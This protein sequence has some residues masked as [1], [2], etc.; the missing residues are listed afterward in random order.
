MPGPIDDLIKDFPVTKSTS[1]KPQ[2]VA[3]DDLIASFPVTPKAGAGRETPVPRGTNVSRATPL[4]SSVNGTNADEDADNLSYATDYMHNM[5]GVENKVEPARKVTIQGITSD[6][7]DAKVEERTYGGADVLQGTTAKKFVKSVQVPA[8]YTED[9]AKRAIASEVNA[10]KAYVAQDAQRLLAILPVQA[11]DLLKKVGM[12]ANSLLQ[13]LSSSTDGQNELSTYYKIRTDVA[14]NEYEQKK[15]AILNSN[16]QVVQDQQQA[17]IGVPFDPFEKRQAVIDQQLSELK[18]GHDRELDKIHNSVFNMAAAKVVNKEF[19]DYGILDKEGAEQA[20]D[21]VSKMLRPEEV[22]RKVLAI[23]GDTA[24]PDNVLKKVM[25]EKVGYQAMKYAMAD[26]YSKG[27]L[28]LA[29]VLNEQT[30]DADRKILDANP[31]YKKTVFANA[32]SKE[33]DKRANRLTNFFLG[34]D[35]DKKFIDGIGQEMGIK[36]EDYKDVNPDDIYQSPNFITKAIGGFLKPVAEFDQFLFDVSGDK[37]SSFEHVFNNSSFG[38]ALGYNKTAENSVDLRHGGTK[39]DTNPES[40]TYGTE[41]PVSGQGKYNLGWNTLGSEIVNGVSTIA[42]MALGSGEISEALMANKLI[43][44]TNAA[45]R[46]GLGI[47]SYVTGYDRSY[48]R[49][50]QAIGSDPDKEPERIGLANVYSTVEALSLQLLPAKQVADK[51]MN[52]VAGQGLV[53]LVMKKGINKVTADMAKPYIIK[54]LQEGLLD[55]GKGVGM[56]VANVL[57]TTA[58]DMA[59]APKTT[60]HD[61]VD[62]VEESVIIGAIQM[63]IPT[64][65]GGIIN[66]KNVGPMHKRAMYEIGTNPEPFIADISKQLT[67]QK[68]T[69]DEARQRID[70]INSIADVYKNSVPSTSVMT[71][72]N[73]TQQQ[74]MDYA[75]SLV[76]EQQLR[77]Q[78]AKTKDQVQSNVLDGQVRDLQAEREDILQS[79]GAQPSPGENRIKISDIVGQKVMYEGKPATISVDE[80]NRVIVTDQKTGVEYDNI[81]NILNVGDES[82]RD[83]G[84]DPLTSVVSVSDAGNIA[85]RGKE[86]ISPVDNP[87]SAINYHNEPGKKGVPVSVTLEQAL[88]NGSTKKVTFRGD[89][90]ED[91][92]YQLHLQK[93]EK[94]NS[95]ER[96]EKFI[97]T[98][99]EARAAIQSEGLPKAA[100]G[101]AAENIEQ[102]SPVVNEGEVVPGEEFPLTS[103]KPNDGKIDEKAQN[104]PDQKNDG[105]NQGGLPE[106]Q[107]LVKVG[108]DDGGK[109]GDEQQKGVKPQKE[110][111]GAEPD[112]ANPFGFESEDPTFDLFNQPAAPE[113]PK[114]PVVEKAAPAS[115]PNGARVESFE[116]AKGSQYVYE[117]DGKT[118]RTTKSGEKNEAQDLI[119]FSKFG[120]ADQEQRFLQGV[121]RS[122]ETGTKVYVID[123]DGKVYDTNEQVKGKD[124]RL[125]LVETATGKILEIADTKQEPTVGYSTFDQRRFDE[126]GVAKRE[127]HIGNPVAKINY[128]PEAVPQAA[129]KGPTPEQQAKAA[130]D[131]FFAPAI[132]EREVAESAK[133]G[134]NVKTR[135]ANAVKVLGRK[136]TKVLNDGSKVDGHYVLTTSDA[137]TPS[138][139][140]KTFRTSEGFPLLEDGRNPNDRDYT[141]KENSDR[142]TIRAANFDGRA[143]EKVPTVDKNGIVIDGNDRTMS[144]QIAAK[145]GTDK[146]YIEAL[147][148]KAD[149]YGFTPEQIEA[150]VKDGKHPRVVF[151]TDKVM[152]YDTHTFSIFNPKT[153]GKVKTPIEEAI[154][155]GRTIDNNVLNGIGQVMNGFDSLAKFFTSKPGSKMVRDI[156]QRNGVFNADNVTGYYRDGKFTNAGKE[157]LQNIILGKVFNEEVLH[158][159]E[160]S[161]AVREKVVYS[162]SNLISIEALGEGYSLQTHLSDALRLKDRVD[163]ILSGIEDKDI[164]KHLRAKGQEDNRHAVK[165]YGLNLFLQQGDMFGQTKF[166][167][168]AVLIWHLLEDNTKKAF[169]DFTKEYL[170]NAKMYNQNSAVDIFGNMRPTREELIRNYNQKVKEYEAT[171]E[172]AVAG[173]PK[174][175]DFDVNAGAVPEVIDAGVRGSGEPK[176]ADVAEPAIQADLPARDAEVEGGEWEALFA[177]PTPEVLRKIAEQEQMEVANAKAAE[178]ENAQVPESKVII[179]PAKPANNGDKS[180]QQQFNEAKDTVLMKERK[181]EG[182]EKEHDTLIRDGKKMRTPDG[183]AA[184]KSVEAKLDRERAALKSAKNKL[185]LAE[186]NVGKVVAKDLAAEIRGRKLDENAYSGPSRDVHGGIVDRASLFDDEVVKKIGV[187][188][189]NAALEVAARAIELGQNVREA[190]Q[191]AVDHIN[192]RH[193]TS[194]NEK[195]FRDNLGEE[196]NIKTAADLRNKKLAEEPLSEKNK[197]AADSLVESV[198]ND[199][200]SLA[201]ALDHIKNLKMDDATKKKLS[202]YIRNRVTEEIHKASG[203]QMAAKHLKLSK[204][205]FDE[206]IRTLGEEFDSVM[207]NATSE[208]Q[209][210]NLRNKFAAAKSGLQSVQTAHAVKNGIITPNTQQAPPT[211]TRFQM[212]SFSRNAAGKLTGKGKFQKA[213]SDLATAVQDK[214]SPLER[215]QE[216]S[217]VPIDEHN[218]AVTAMR[219]KKSKAW[220]KISQMRDYLGN[221]EHKKGSLFDR[222]KKADINI[223][224]FGL[225]LYAKHAKE[226]NDYNAQLRQRIFDAKVYELNQK[227]AQAQGKPHLQKR[228]ADQLQEIL[229]QKDS[230]YA[231]MPDG[232]SGMT[233]LQAQDILDEVALDPKKAEYEAFEQEFRDNV[234]GK[235]L[236]TKHEAG[237]ISDEDYQH[238]KHYYKNYVPL[239]VKDE[240]ILAENGGIEDNKFF[241]NS[242]INGRELYRS[243]GADYRSMLD[244][245]NPLLQAAMD[246]EHSFVKGEENKANTVLSNFVRSN[247]NESIWE[248]KSA[249]YEYITDANGN[250]VKAFEKDE[251]RPN[252]AIPYYENGAKKYIILRDKNL[253]LMN[254]KVGNNAFLRM[255]QPVSHFIASVNTLS[256]P[257]FFLKNIFYDQQDAYMSLLGNENPE[258]V[259]KFRSYNPA[260]LAKEIITGKTTGDWAKWVQEWKDNGGAISFVDAITTEKQ[261]ELSSKVFDGYDKPFSVSRRRAVLEK[262]KEFATV[263][264]QTTRV[265]AYRAAVE[266]EAARI[267]KDEGIPVA[268]AMD[269]VN[270]DK[271]AVVS[272]NA[273]VDFEKKGVYG[274]YISSFKAFANA[275]IQGT[276]NLMYLAA[277][278]PKVRKFLG[279]MVLAGVAE[280]EVARMLGD[281]DPPSS[282]DCYLGVPDWRKERNFLIPMKPFGGQGFLSI[283]LGRNF[284]WFN[285]VGKKIDEFVHGEIDNAE[286][287]GHS[288]GSML[289]YYDP[290]GGT[291]PIEQKMAGNLAPVVQL[292]TNKSHFGQ[293]IE[294]ENKAG[295]FPSENFFPKT[296]EEFVEAAHFLHKISGGNAEEPG[297]IEISPDKLQ[298]TVQSIFGGLGNFAG[299]TYGM[300]ENAAAGQGTKANDV[301]IARTFYRTSNMARIKQE[302]QQIADK[303]REVVLSEKDMEKLQADLQMLVEGNHITEA[304]AEKRMKYIQSN[305][306]K[307][308]YQIGKRI[309]GG[310]EPATE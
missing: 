159:L 100:E 138:H 200:N 300:L 280:A 110:V 16:P 66:A 289:D 294:P 67:N 205:D 275:G 224:K 131:K 4:Q 27:D 86:Y 172:K 113:A 129:A 111:S 182:L 94:D 68:L 227:I 135:F 165:Q 28:T 225:Y 233:N 185:K 245:N 81:G 303:S 13:K 308:T 30:K 62:E 157:L 59:F 189:H 278:S 74:Q 197:L 14:N 158:L 136:T 105:G 137:V 26:A 286:F 91:I 54:G 264:E 141:K 155:Y 143:A 3:G 260:K 234:V 181:I 84:I 82:V 7:P 48:Q 95:H 78:M 60:R 272:R 168:D 99:E 92:M 191:S 71:G 153:E 305:Q 180:V 279:A 32:I 20:K 306:N 226:R 223:D 154:Q 177:P 267:A 96:L 73:L 83:H 250:I 15:Q 206:A 214:Y 193:F 22:G 230:R 47:Y 164:A 128:S 93:L 274:A 178:Q 52:T 152:P 247:P 301:P 204:G 309:E 291:A 134:D 259:K 253:V 163:E 51:W 37:N 282:E 50:K 77:D 64:I 160:A 285:F 166:S 25:N 57:G 133:V 122:E 221:M 17:A 112:P 254:K 287:F 29:K 273:T 156:L 42:T 34:V 256:N 6:T 186:R 176:Q 24:P 212:P 85:V 232:G 76:A 36:P 218:D 117:A 236:D 281:C 118:R 148:E 63:A 297:K 33:I 175:I 46:V 203:E 44:N 276:T 56:G 97:N 295:L 208:E 109:V 120:D 98:D 90:A 183:Q 194:W 69:P 217:L 265:M 53:D 201:S 108:N 43:T 261:A 61:V 192:D 88:P 1:P 288:I 292:S 246:L 231:L 21:A 257:E 2:A 241:S 151:V 9:D 10:S 211:G 244:R 195:L 184:L 169:R 58:A 263:L 238:L 124:V 251:T 72:E 87:L 283:P 171:K 266:G 302:Y 198:R 258:L 270:R 19:A 220:E 89:V 142:V 255:A 126:D 123:R 271:A 161:P 190:I 228:Y 119:V 268:Q 144:G 299:S 216:G 252:N 140:S 150:M 242:A 210:A 174:E 145:Q 219:L 147:K 49:A 290:S 80:A 170:E 127:K 235:I 125:A 293:P 41:I 5:L 107:E 187:K 11:T 207:A 213:K 310:E 8:H 199:K 18:E 196:L 222:M 307:V 229:Q 296:P 179:E 45:H 121:Q 202:T 269:K 188:L 209:K 239:K 240:V 101:V 284:G 70:A 262:F 149:V 215:A 79:A 237:M 23:M 173:P 102:I 298:F 248:I 115:A 65:G 132:G 55:L 139:D 38:K 116:T 35:V 243:K 162:M 103:K 277:K 12:D 146:A 106:R 39:I 75:A 104:G 31:E 40:P 249:E 304:Q 130:A 114:L 167:E